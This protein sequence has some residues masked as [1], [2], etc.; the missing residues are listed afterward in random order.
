MIDVLHCVDLGCAS[1]V[2]ANIFMDCIK[3]NVWRAGKMEDNVACL[4]GELKKWHSANKTK[5]KIQGELSISRLR[6]AGGYPKLKAKAAATRFIADFALDLAKKHCNHDRRIVAVALCLC[7]FYNILAAEPMHMSKNAC[8]ELST[9]GR[10][11]CQLYGT[12]SREAATQRKRMWKATPKWH[13]FL[14]LCEWQIPELRM[15]PRA[16]WTYA[17]EDLVGQLVEIAESCHVQTLSATSLTK[18]LIGF[19]D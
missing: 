9:I 3:R 19:L 1:H 6:T 8:D 4:N 11:L 12:L 17:D 18:W 13:L 16:Y 2:I 5:C 10:Q 15:N 14:P 7:R